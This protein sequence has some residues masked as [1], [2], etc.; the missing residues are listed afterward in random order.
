MRDRT[1]AIQRGAAPATRSRLVH[2]LRKIGV[3]PGAVLMIH[4]RLSALG[5]VVGGSGTVVHALLDALGPEGTLMAYAG[6]EDD[7]YDLDDLP[8]VWRAAYEADLPPFDPATSEAT[9]DNGRLPERIRTWP[10]AH[11]SRQPEASVVALGARAAWLTAEHPWDDPYGPGS[12]LAKLVEADGQVLMLGAPLET[13]TLLHHA[14]ATA[15]VPEKRRVTYRMPLLEDGRTVW[16]TFRDIDT[17]TGAFDYALVADEIARTPGCGPETDAFEA[18][19]R[20]ALLA[21][22]GRRGAVGEGESHLFP[23]RELLAFAQ[24]WLEERFAA[25]SDSPG[26]PDP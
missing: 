26:D 18:I 9:R 20:R 3:R 24:R 15:R 17:S 12:P 11:R 14:E 4:T 22:I 25:A 2:D 7:S 1:E 5:W 6:W 23:A 10:G 16:R 13:I 21:G 19:S 8:P